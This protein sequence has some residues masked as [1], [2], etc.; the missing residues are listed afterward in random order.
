MA[1]LDLWNMTDGAEG[2][3]LTKTLEEHYRLSKNPKF[4]AMRCA[5]GKRG[6][7]PCT[8]CSQVCPKGIYPTEKT[9]MPNFS[10]CIGCGLCSAACPDKCIAPPTPA[11][12]AYL[13]QQ[14]RAGSLEVSCR[15]S[16]EEDGLKLTCLAALSWEQMALA[17]L[18]G[19][20]S[21]DLSHC[22]TCEDATAKAALLDN[23][24]KCRFFLGDEVFRE[25]VILEKEPRKV[26]GTPGSVS[27][28]E[29]FTSFFEMDVDRAFN[30]L[31]ALESKQ[32]N[33]LL[34]RAML[35]DCV[36]S[37]AAEHTPDQRPKYRVK[38]PAFTSDCF[39]CGSCAWK[40]PQKALKLQNEGTSILVTVEVWRCT[41][42]GLC[43]DVCKNGGIS[44]LSVMKVS[45]LGK[46]ALKRIPAY[47][48]EDCGNPRPKDAPEGVCGQCLGKRK[49]ERIRQQRER[50]RLEKTQK[51]EQL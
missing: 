3:S 13:K 45:G 46:T 12:V 2:F 38:L 51:Q 40:C 6:E 43:A 9:R 36:R 48:C 4:N 1:L 31:P 14:S 49:M 27:R 22:E 42:C 41:G 47:L 21:L 16:R 17:A 11:A 7:D 32:D 34:Y 29:L 15:H 19:G 50:E 24:E 18:S 23:L 30:A 33:G 8:L 10:G 5:S 44:G 26:T 25:K 28:R 35:R 20:L 37:V 39:N